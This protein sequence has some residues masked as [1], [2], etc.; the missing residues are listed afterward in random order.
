MEQDKQ[1]SFRKPYAEIIIIFKPIQ[2][3]QSNHKWK[4]NCLKVAL[5][6]NNANDLSKKIISEADRQVNFGTI[7]KYHQFY[8]FLT[9]T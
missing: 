2:Q 8:Y 6:L 3:T 9:T 4:R 1:V 7:L 5:D